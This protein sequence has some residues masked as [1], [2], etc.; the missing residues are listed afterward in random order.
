MRWVVFISVL[1]LVLLSG[2]LDVITTRQKQL[3]LSSTDFSKTSIPDCNG[4]STCFKK[5]DGVGLIV[6]DTAPLKPKTRF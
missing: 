3:C 6:N 5:I 1:F 4:F 2:C